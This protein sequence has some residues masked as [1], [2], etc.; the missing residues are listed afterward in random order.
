MRE[1]GGMECV[2]DLLQRYGGKASSERE[3]GELGVSKLLTTDID[4]SSKGYHRQVA[5]RM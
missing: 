4:H 2:T 3:R 5:F 1:E